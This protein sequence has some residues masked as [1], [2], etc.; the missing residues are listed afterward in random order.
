[1]PGSDHSIKRVIRTFRGCIP[2]ALVTAMILLT[3]CVGREIRSTMHGAM[4]T[5]FI[6]APPGAH[7]EVNGEYIGDA[8]M[9]YSWP[10]KYRDG[11]EF[12]DK[13]TIRA[14]PS[15]S[16]QF[17]QRKFFDSGWN[18]SAIP[19]RVYFDMHAPAPPPKEDE[20]D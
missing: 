19:S 9:V 12:A 6:S 16:G 5:E 18:K 17:P 4:N 14:L 8:P 2:L 10:R 11:S 15:G 7:I 3:G 20:H 1:M 13:M